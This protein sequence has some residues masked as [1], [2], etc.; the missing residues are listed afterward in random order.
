M[1]GHISIGVRD[2]AGATAFYDAALGVMGYVRLWT[3]GIG[4]GTPGG[5][6]KLNIFQRA[7]ASRPG[8][9][10]HIAF[11]APDQAAVRTFYAAALANGGTDNGAP[12]LRLNYGP[13]YYAA[14]VIDPEGHHLEAM[15]Q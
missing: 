11:L 3:G 15:L 2:L 14:F 10:F 13:S 9:G 12:G 5:G 4:Y 1:L 6:E 7:D 8:P